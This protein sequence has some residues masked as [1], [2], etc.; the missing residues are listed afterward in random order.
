MISLKSLIKTMKEAK[1]T[2][3]KKGVETPLD[4]KIQIP[5]YGV[6]KRKQLQG[7]IKRVLNDTAKYVKKGQMENAYNVLYKRNLLKGFLET[8]IKHSGK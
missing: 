7:S 5:G 1:L 2:L 3:P 4:A 8:E 6:M